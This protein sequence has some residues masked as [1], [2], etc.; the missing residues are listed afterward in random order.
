ML[1]VGG[2]EGMGPVEATVDS[3]AR[4]CGPRLQLVVVCGRN[5]RLIR[6]LSEKVHSSRWHIGRLQLCLNCYASYAASAGIAL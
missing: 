2:G 4:K 6:R 3:I 1:L 5:E